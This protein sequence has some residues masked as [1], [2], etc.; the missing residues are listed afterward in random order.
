VAGHNKM[1]IC[2]TKITKSPTWYCIMWHIVVGRV[3]EGK[4]MQECSKPN[5][6]KRLG[7]CVCVCVCVLSIDNFV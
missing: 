6:E 5:K 1:V 2:N 4:H 3:L 7:V